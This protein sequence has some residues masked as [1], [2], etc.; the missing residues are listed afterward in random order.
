MVIA[1]VVVITIVVD[2]RS[3][4]SQPASHHQEVEWNLR[5]LE[6]KILGP[7]LTS[8]Y[9]YYPLIS[10]P[11]VHHDNNAHREYVRRSLAPLR[12][13]ARASFDPCSPG[14]SSLDSAGTLLGLRRAI[15]LIFYCMLLTS[16]AI[17]IADVS[18]ATVAPTCGSL[19]GQV[20]C[21][22]SS[23]CLASPAGT[24]MLRYN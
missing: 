15:R 18:R 11:G 17:A 2:Q 5:I 1:V 23:S 9:L 19:S 22:R 14:K 16:R 12:L 24:C 21:L 3:A 20:K 10:L 6:W 8:L 13:P 4:S 7:G